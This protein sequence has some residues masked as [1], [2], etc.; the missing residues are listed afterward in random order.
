MIKEKVCVYTCITGD[1]D[2]LKEIQNIEQG[3]DYYCF[4][5][6]KK[7]KSN[8]WKVVYIKD[9]KLTNVQLARKIKI[10]GHPIIN[11]NYDIQLWMDGAVVFKKNITLFINTFMKKNDL[12]VAFRHGERDNIKDE[13]ENCI[14]LKKE[15]KEKVK[16]LLE[17]YDN[18]HYP[19]KNGLIES[20]VYIKRNKNELVRKT[21]KIW[22]EMIL[23]YS[24]R[25]Q[26]SFNY[27]IYKTGL[28]VKW[29]NEK[30]FDNNWFD[31]I[32]HSTYKKNIN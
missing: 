11:D 5:N 30:V 20:T 14:R 31:W 18:N 13:C 24:H 16:K 6:N 32:K 19:D 22:F 26:L 9:D 29:I 27:C 1:Y 12:F 15:T 23:N 10:L 7:I 8:T 2:N 3:I 25:D 28:N 4:T 17:F 21:M